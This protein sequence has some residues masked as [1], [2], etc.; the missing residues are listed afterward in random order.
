M[1]VLTHEK[2][3]RRNAK[4]GQYTSLVA[5][6]ILGGGMYVSFVYPTQLYISF[7][8][9]T[10]GFVLSQVG[11]YFGNRW[12]RRPRVDERLTAALKGLTKDYTL[13]HFLTPV[14]HLLV[15][16]AGIWIIEAYYQRGTI[17]YEGNKWK[18]KGGGLLLGYL[19][20]FAQEGLGRPD[21]EVK[22][23]T[24]SLAE[25]FKKA[26]GDG[27]E[28]PPIHAALVFTDDR[29]EIKAD[30]APIPT[31]KIDQLKEL[32]RK[33]AKQNPFPATEIKRVTAVLPEESIA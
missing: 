25:A 20:I 18:Q 24:E 26:L 31:I 17:V 21:I 11:I 10:V 3:I 32:M 28:V 13:Y 5:L 29:A 8:S 23:D 14:N 12:G 15:G 1:N 6:L 19:K 27:Q 4:I 30:E 33:T 9:L 16:P 7:I 2:N 22:A